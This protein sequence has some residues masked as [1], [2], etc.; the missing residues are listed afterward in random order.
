MA[1]VT[2]P[3]MFEVEENKLQRD[4]YVSWQTV[5]PLEE[6]GPNF[7]YEVQMFD[8]SDGRYVKSLVALI[9]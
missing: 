9:S 5:D 1:P 6:N 2:T 3:G 8:H 4:V 7:A